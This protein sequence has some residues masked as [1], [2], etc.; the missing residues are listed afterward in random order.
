M[1]RFVSRTRSPTLSGPPD[2]G[3]G[4]R[5]LRLFTGARIFSSISSQA[6]SRAPWSRGR[7]SSTHTCTCLPA[8]LAART[9]PSAVPWTLAA[10]S[11]AI[12]AWHVPQSFGTFGLN[13]FDAGS[14]P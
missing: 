6:V 7:V 9:I 13:V 2:L 14:D 3:R 5:G 8:S 11:F 4:S 12:S 1:F 10:Y